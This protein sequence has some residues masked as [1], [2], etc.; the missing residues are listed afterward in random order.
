M[1]EWILMA[2][3]NLIKFCATKIPQFPNFFPKTSPITDK[4]Y[5]QRYWW[6]QNQLL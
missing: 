5:C 4:R 1:D 2:F 6:C 3:V